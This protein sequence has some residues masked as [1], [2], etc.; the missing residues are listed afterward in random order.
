MLKIETKYIRKNK[1][2]STPEGDVVSTHDSIN[3]AKKASSKLQGGALG[4]GVLQ[5]DQCLT[6]RVPEALVMTNKLIN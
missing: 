6:G 4:Q 1:T 5:L 3:L 2:I